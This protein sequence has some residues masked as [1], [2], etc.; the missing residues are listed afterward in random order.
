[1]R[2][3]SESGTHQP[4]RKKMKRL[5]VALV[6]VA[7][8]TAGAVPALGRGPVTNF[9]AHLSG[10]DE[11]PPVETRAQGQAIF[12]LSSDGESLGFKLIVANLV[13]TLQAHIHIGPPGANGPVVAF[14]YPEGPPPQLIEGAFSG[15]LARGVITADDLRGPLA[16]AS[17][18][19]LIA[20]I[21][22]G[23]AYVNV[24]TVANPG[25]E[26]RGQID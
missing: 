20:E 14:L 6:A 2:S 5:A 23:N 13:D 8:F 11:V 17:M 21:E 15:V 12:Q 18:A 3:G 4:R 10:A 1:M 16:G 22:N 7:L 24:H 19:D 26:I 25:G 9:R